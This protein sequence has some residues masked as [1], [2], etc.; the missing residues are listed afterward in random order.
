MKKIGEEVKFREKKEKKS[1]KKKKK[2]KQ[3]TWYFKKIKEL[4][5]Q[6]NEYSTNKEYLVYR[7]YDVY[8]NDY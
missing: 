3:C 2:E 7:R 6:K 1:E 4:C 5:H 8:I